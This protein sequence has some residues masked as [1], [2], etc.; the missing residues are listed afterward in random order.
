MLEKLT[1][2][3]HLHAWD[4]RY[5]F[6][7]SGGIGDFLGEENIGFYFGKDGLASFELSRLFG[8]TGIRTAAGKPLDIPRDGPQW[9]GG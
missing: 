1:E 2:D 8:F 9:F 3:V 6:I 4:A 5:Q 7:E